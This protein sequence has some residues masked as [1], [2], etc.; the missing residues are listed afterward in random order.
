[1]MDLR[2]TEAKDQDPVRSTVQTQEELCVERSN[3]VRSRLSKICGIDE[4]VY[5]DGLCT[6][7]IKENSK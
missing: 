4:I 1:M 2:D 6:T 5:L 3:H 7:F